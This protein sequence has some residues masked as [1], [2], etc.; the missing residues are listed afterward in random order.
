MKSKVSFILLLTIFF[1]TGC[2]DNFSKQSTPEWVDKILSRTTNNSSLVGAWSYSSIVSYNNT[3]C[4][5]EG[6]LSDYNGTV[7]YGEMDGIRTENLLLTYSDF[8]Q[9]GYTENAFQDM[10]SQKNGSLNTS[11]DCELTW[12]THFEYYLTDDGYCESY[13]KN[14]SKEKFITFC[15]ILAQLDVSTEITFSWDS[16]KTEKSGCKIV[17]LT[18]Q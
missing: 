16:D 14:S 12:D 10:C 13:S 17:G 2:E 4:L 6:A 15:G 5:G 1:P 3:N 9:K 8:Q 11:G 18:I 7:T